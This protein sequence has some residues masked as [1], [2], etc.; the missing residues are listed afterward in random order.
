LTPLLRVT[1]DLIGGVGFRLVNCYHKRDLQFTA[2]QSG[3]V[4]ARQSCVRMNEINWVSQMQA[5]NFRQ[6]AREKKSSRGRETETAGQRKE[7]TP[8]GWDPG[9]AGACVSAVKRLHCDD[10]VHH[11]ESF[12]P[13]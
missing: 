7:A 11:A 4:P 5:A 9:A 10:R 13:G 8:T 6:K 12:Q 2:E 3:G 1:F